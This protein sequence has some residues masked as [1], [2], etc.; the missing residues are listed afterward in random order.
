MIV[1]L[2]SSQPCGWLG[3]TPIQRG[4][5]WLATV[6]VCGGAADEFV[7]TLEALDDAGWARRGIY[8]YPE[9]QLRTVEWI[10]VHTVHELLHHRVDIGTLA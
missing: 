10:A 4:S 7:A 2:S 6:G 3:V 8:N 1:R 9:P 5:N